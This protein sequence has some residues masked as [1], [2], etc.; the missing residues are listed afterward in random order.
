MFGETFEEEMY[1][2][3][4]AEL[5]C[6]VAR[7]IANERQE[8]DKIEYVHEFLFYLFDLF[9]LLVAEDNTNEEDKEAKFKRVVKV[10]S[11]AIERNLLARLSEQF[12]NND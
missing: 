1:S 3:A 2:N 10:I 11:L 9:T 7:Y 6:M 12:Y 4:T 8:V 5:L